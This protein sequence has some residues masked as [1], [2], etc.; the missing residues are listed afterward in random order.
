MPI[1]P[2][3]TERIDNANNRLKKI[4]DGL[5]LSSLTTCRSFVL[6][7]WKAK[8]RDKQPM[9]NVTRESKPKTILT[10]RFER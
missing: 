2:L 1:T 9:A 8:K 10:Q 6:F 3:I 4:Y 5:V 7:N